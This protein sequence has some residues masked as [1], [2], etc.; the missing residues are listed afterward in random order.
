MTRFVVPPGT[1]SSL[2]VPG[3]RARTVWIAAALFLF[4]LAFAVVEA[5]AAPRRAAD[6]TLCAR[7]A[8]PGGSD[9][10]PRSGS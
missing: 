4:I 5:D 6:G 9:A 1:S 10:G 7:Y 2:T 3:Q 8:S